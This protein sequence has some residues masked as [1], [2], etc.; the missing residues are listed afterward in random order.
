MLR[1]KEERFLKTTWTRMLRIDVW[2]DI[3]RN[4]KVFCRERRIGTVKLV[5]E[6]RF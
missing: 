2:P 5:T 3:R 4:V 1:Q 6:K